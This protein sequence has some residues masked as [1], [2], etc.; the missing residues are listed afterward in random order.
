MRE[1]I[2]EKNHQ[3][4]LFLMAS[5]IISS[6][7]SLLYLYTAKRKLWA[8]NTRNEMKIEQ[9]Y[10]L[11]A[12]WISRVHI[13]MD[14][15]YISKFLFSFKFWGIF[16]YVWK[17]DDTC[18]LKIREIIRPETINLLFR[19]MLIHIRKEASFIFFRCPSIYFWNFIVYQKSIG[20]GRSYIGV[21]II[22]FS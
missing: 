4:P 13:Q 16:I 7:T 19:K 20:S 21:I 6:I 22:C 3:H 1:L 9:Q 8:V 18:F 2:S 17:K 14:V 12:K 15:V 11:E 5:S 10:N